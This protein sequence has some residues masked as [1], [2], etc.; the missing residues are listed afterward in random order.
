MNDLENKLNKI[1]NENIIWYI[2]IFIAIFALVSNYFESDYLKNK[3][4]HEYIIY[5]DINIVILIVSILI[6]CYFIY[7]NYQNCQKQNPHTNSQSKENNDL[8]LIASILILIAGLIYL[9]TTIMDT[10]E[11]E[12][13]II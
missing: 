9:Y 10:T 7:N 6:Y 11:D 5:H 3:N 13:A 1:S 4:H 8:N 12:V 2:Y